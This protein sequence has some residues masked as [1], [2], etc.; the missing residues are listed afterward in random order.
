V[1]V[2]YYPMTLTGSGSRG[3]TESQLQ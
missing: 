2:L 3:L 1:P